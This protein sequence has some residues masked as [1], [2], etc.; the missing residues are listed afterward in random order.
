MESIII[1]DRKVCSRCQGRCHLRLLD[2][3]LLGVLVSRHVEDVFQRYEAYGLVEAMSRDFKVESIDL[4]RG[5]RGD[6]ENFSSR[7]CQFESAIVERLSLDTVTLAGGMW[8]TCDFDVLSIEWG[9]AP[10]S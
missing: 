3:Y 6:I 8:R 7:R 1:G 5:Y 10:R 4:S 9:L 2:I